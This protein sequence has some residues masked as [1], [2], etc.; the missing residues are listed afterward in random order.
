M[1]GRRQRSLYVTEPCWAALRWLRLAGERSEGKT[2]Y[3]IARDLTKDAEPTAQGARP[4]ASYGPRAADAG[5]RSLI[6]AIVDYER[7]AQQ[8]VE[9]RTVDGLGVFVQPCMRQMVEDHALAPGDPALERLSELR[10]AEEVPR[11]A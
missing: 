8:D 7:W 2:V 9:R 10:R 5:R 11:P 3:V 6:T 1:D 4:V